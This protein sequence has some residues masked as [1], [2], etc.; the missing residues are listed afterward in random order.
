MLVQDKVA[1][2]TGGG[3]GMGRAIC[4]LFAAE[5]ARVV[6]ADLNLEA[7]RA[8]A[9]E[10]ASETVAYEVNVAHDGQ[11]KGL[12]EHTIERF[13][14]VDIL[15]NCAGVPMPFTP[16]EEV[17]EEQWD[18]IFDVN[19]KS[20]F[21]TAKHVV[22]HMKQN[23]R[24]AIL[25]I[26]SIAGVRA[27]PGLN[28][29]C[30]SKGAAIMLTKALALELAPY[31]IRVNGI[32]PGPAETPMLSKFMTGDEEKIERET[33]EIFINS[34]PLGALIQ[35]DDIAQAALYLC[36]DAAKMVTGEIVNVDGGRG[37]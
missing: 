19:T 34:V 7:A 14:R 35:P 22:P 29:Y 8:T 27:R 15:V 23:G 18:R 32:N 13:G 24:G 21:L 30:A 6:V 37:I 25:N 5:G 31:R 17:T 16:V 33:K 36:S 10:C 28:A 3:S 1:I 9:S 12:V 2:V 11:V 26:C 20:I 4:R